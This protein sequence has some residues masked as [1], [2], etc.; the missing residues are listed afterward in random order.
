M[1]VLLFFLLNEMQISEIFPEAL[2]LPSP[3]WADGLRNRFSSV[4]HAR[5]SAFNK[6]FPF[7]GHTEGNSAVNKTLSPLLG[8]K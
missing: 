3:K 2:L 5:E 1:F 6:R 8:P 7:E 4:T